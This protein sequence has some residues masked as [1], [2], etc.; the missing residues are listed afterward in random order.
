MCKVFVKFNTGVP[1]IAACERLFGV[2]KDVFSAKWNWLSDKKKLWQ[3][4][5]VSC[6]QAI[7]PWHL[8]L[9]PTC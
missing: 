6:Q 4:S 2:G 7:L 9:V 3:T 5:H 1:A 8:V